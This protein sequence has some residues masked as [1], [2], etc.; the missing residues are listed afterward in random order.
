MAGLEPATYSLPWSCSTA[1]LH[2]RGR[3]RTCTCEVQRTTAL[4]T[5]ALA[6]PPRAR[7][8]DILT[9]N[10][11][12]SMVFWCFLRHS[13]IFLWLP[14]SKTF[15]AP[16]LLNISGLVYC[17]YSANPLPLVTLSF[18]NCVFPTTPGTNL[19]TASVTIVAGNSPPIRT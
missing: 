9:E 8:K 10:R 3:G 1:E 18:K 15:G 7:F 13:S 11:F 5:V 12:Y 19:V 2:R 16:H 6:A 17:G 4:Q 14:E